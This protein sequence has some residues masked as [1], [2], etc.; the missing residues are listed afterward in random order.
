MI[1][2]LVDVKLRKDWA[3]EVHWEN[4]FVTIC[5]FSVIVVKTW[6]QNVQNF[7]SNA[8]IQMS[9]FLNGIGIKLLLC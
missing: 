7:C 3:A 6:F 9:K 5:L 1:S 8:H 4:A 2:F